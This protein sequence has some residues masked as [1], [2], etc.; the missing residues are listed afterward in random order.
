MLAEDGRNR[1]GIQPVPYATVNGRERADVKPGEKVTIHVVV[2][3]PCGTGKVVKAD[4]RLD[5]TKQFTLPV[6]LGAAKYSAD[7]EHVEFDTTI[8]YDKAG[9]Y[10]PTVKVYSE[11]KGDASTP[12]TRIAN[13]GKVRVVVKAD[14]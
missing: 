4:W 7:G 13:L 9:T 5:D 1:G 10:F 3:V 6:D 8:S 14:R 12:Y 11:R 2:D